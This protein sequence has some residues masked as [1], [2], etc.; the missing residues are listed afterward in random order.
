M[1]SFLPCV[2]SV[3]HFAFPAFLRPYQ[4]LYPQ[5]YY[6]IYWPDQ[7]NNVCKVDLYAPH[8]AVF[9]MIAVLL[10]TYELCTIP[11]VRKAAMDR[12]YALIVMEDENTSYQTIGPVSKMINVVARFHAEGHD[13]FAYKEHFRKR[14]DFMWM[15]EEGL[16]MTGTNGSQLWDTA[17]ITQAMSESGLANLEENRESMV[18]ALE[19]LDQSQIR[20]NPKHYHDAFRH[21][22]KGAWSFRYACCQPVRFRLIVLST[23]EQGYTVSDCTGEGLK[24]VIYLQELEYVCLRCLPIVFAYL[25]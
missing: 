19:W 13:S 1:I 14:A 22:T 6:S 3:F 5:D 7:R 17:F 8:S 10:S 11:P 15:C 18:K 2:R 23:K 16:M 4:E 9:D 21:S 12:A 25:L 24:S 20:E